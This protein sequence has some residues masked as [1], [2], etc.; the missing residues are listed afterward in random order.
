MELASVYREQGRCPEALAQVTQALEAFDTRLGPEH[1]ESVMAC[2]Q[3]AL[4]A[5]DCRSS[6]DGAARFEQLRREA[7]R[8]FASLR[9]TLGDRNVELLRVL[10]YFAELTAKTPAARAQALER[11]REAV[12]GFL[13]LYGEGGPTLADLRLKQGK[14]LEQMGQP[15]QALRTYDRAQR[16]LDRSFSRH[17]VRAELLTAMGDIYDAKGQ[18]D[19][20]RRLWQDAFGILRDTYGPD[21][22]RVARFRELRGRERS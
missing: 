18:N 12:D 3:A 13:S 22:P 4:L 20:A 8:G 17:P 21:H 6:P 5:A 7:T 19:V 1:K 10:V 16:L 14:L 15:D 9:E 2:L 11:Y